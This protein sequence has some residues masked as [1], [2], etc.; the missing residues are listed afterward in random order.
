MI[1]KE[2]IEIEELNSSIQNDD[3]KKIKDQ[4]FGAFCTIT[5]GIMGV[6]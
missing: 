3:Y 1:M 2:T 4:R 6:G 5:S